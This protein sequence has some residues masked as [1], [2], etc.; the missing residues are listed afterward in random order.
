MT[1]VY[2]YMEEGNTWWK[3][4][5]EFDDTNTAIDAKLKQEDDSNYD[6][7]FTLVQLYYCHKDTP[8]FQHNYVLDSCSQLVTYAVV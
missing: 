1:T 3:Y 7:V 5:V 4:V 2:G 6:N 8:Q